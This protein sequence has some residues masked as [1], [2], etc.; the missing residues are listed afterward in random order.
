MRSQGTGVRAE[1][2]HEAEDFVADVEFGNVVPTASTTPAKSTPSVRHLGRRHPPI[3]RQK[4]GWA[5]L[6]W[7]SVW[8]TVEARTR[9][10]TS[11]AAGTGRSTSSICRTSGGP[12]RSRTT[13]RIMKARRAAESMSAVGWAAPTASSVMR[14]GACELDDQLPE[15]TP[16]GGDVGVGRVVVSLDRHRISVVN[17]P[18]ALSADCRQHQRRAQTSPPRRRR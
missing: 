16:G 10:S 9:M 14:S 1:P 12:Y 2:R 13:A 8:L 18:D 3:R 17:G 5:A 11:P 7:A 6:T 15:V 4:T